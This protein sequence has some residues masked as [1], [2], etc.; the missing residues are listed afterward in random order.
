MKITPLVLLIASNAFAAAPWE[1][2]TQGAAEENSTRRALA[3]VALG[4][5]RTPQA[6]KL[7]LAAVVDKAPA[8]RLAA[9]SALA[10]QKSRAAIPKRKAALD[11]EAA[12]ISF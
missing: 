10:E 2:L 4:T 12:E 1:L 5:I 11:D 7:V 3:I 8:V 6:D 9:V